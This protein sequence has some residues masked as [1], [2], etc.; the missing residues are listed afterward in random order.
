[1]DF[2][3]PESAALIGLHFVEPLLEQLNRFI[4]I[5]QKRDIFIL[6]LIRDLNG[7]RQSI[8]RLYADAATALT[9]TA[10]N[11]ANNFSAG[12]YR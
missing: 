6:E 1:M 7:M 5:C 8:K 9:G 11:K 10:F 12:S 4:K 2:S 3:E